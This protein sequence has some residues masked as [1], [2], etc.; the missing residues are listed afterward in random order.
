MKAKADFTNGSMPI[1]QVWNTSRSG[2]LFDHDSYLDEQTDGR[3]RSETLP[4]KG[5]GSRNKFSDPL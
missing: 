4:G 5:V 2:R 1:L 3:H